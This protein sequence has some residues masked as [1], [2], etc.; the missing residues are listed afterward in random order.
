MAELQ[1]ELVAPDRKVWSGTATMV[2]ART[3]DGEIGVLPGHTPVLGVLQTGSIRVDKADG[4]VLLAAVDGGFLS[5]ANDQVSILAEGAELAEEIDVAAAEAE[6]AR[7]RASGDADSAA[8]KRAEAR[9]QAA[10]GRMHAR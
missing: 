8:Q 5:V 4:G 3:L 2:V 1:V 9:L 10:E 6:L 7:L